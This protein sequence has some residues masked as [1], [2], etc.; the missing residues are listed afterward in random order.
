MADLP[1][2]VG[3]GIIRIKLRRVGVVASNDQ[4]AD[5]QAVTGKVIFTPSASIMKHVGQGLMFPSFPVVANLNANGDA[6][7]ELMATDDPQITPTGWTYK[8]TFELDDYIEV[9]SFSITV[10]EGSDRSLSNLTPVVDNTGTYYV[11]VGPPGPAGP[12]ST[13]PGPAGPTGPTG[14]EGPAGPAS[15][16]P[17]PTGPTGP[18]GPAGADAVVDA[19]AVAN[20][21]GVTLWTADTPPTSGT[22]YDKPVL[23]VSGGAVLTPVPVTPTMPQ[24]NY[25]TWTVTAPVTV[26]VE[27]QI[28][29]G[30]NVIPLPQ[31][32]AY[33]VSGF[34][35]PYVLKLRTAALPGYVLTGTYQWDR[36]LMDTASL[37]IYASD[38]FA[39]TAGTKLAPT[40]NTVGVAFNNGM[41]GSNTVNFWGPLG[42]PGGWRTYTDATSIE[43]DAGY[44]GVDV[45]HGEVDFNIGAANWGIE[46]DTTS[47]PVAHSRSIGI[48]AGMTNT[49]AATG[50]TVTAYLN[51]NNLEARYGASGGVTNQDFLMRS[52]VTEANLLGIWRFT[53]VN[54]FFQ[55]TAPTG[56]VAG[57]DYSAASTTFGTWSELKTSD[58]SAAGSKLFV[59][60]GGMRLY[61]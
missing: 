41:G 58:F 13:V 60:A 7:V 40:A 29:D 17:G 57:K 23:W 30:A 27:Y 49:N 3:T 54:K 33:S 14:P 16:V 45:S 10:P 39:R 12:A 56:E 4:D 5:V 6:D 59:R 48:T 26:G 51:G 2:D 9:D 37:A 31:G 50:V 28:L 20:I 55:V 46:I 52:A 43:Y 11:M 19:A 44:A 8:V 38:S 25:T 42:A 21:L 35:R 32:T 47:W 22:L 53:W 61:R 36:M 15:T 34:A 1:A 18:S 24:V